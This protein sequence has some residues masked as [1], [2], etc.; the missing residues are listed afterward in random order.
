VRIVVDGESHST[1]LGHPFEIGDLT[2]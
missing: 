2:R 1:T